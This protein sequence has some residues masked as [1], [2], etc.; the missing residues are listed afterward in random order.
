M[1]VPKV[2]VIIPTYNYA[3]FI[4]EAIES[5]IK[6]TY[7]IGNIEIIVVDDGS[8]DNTNDVLKEYIDSGIIQYHYQENHGKA[9]ATYQAVQKCTGKYIF[10][11]DADD[12]FFPDKIQ[13]YVN[14]FE[15]DEK[16]VH[17]ATPN[18]LLYEKDGSV[19]IEKI[20]LN[21][22]ERTFD[23]SALLQRLYNNNIFFGGGSTFAAR[24]KT[25]RS[26]TI[27]AGVDMFIDEFLLLALLPFG[28]SYFINRP[29][30]TWRV[31]G[32]NFS[33]RN[34]SKENMAKNQERLLNSSASVLD[35]LTQNSYDRDIIKIYRLLHATRK[36]SFKESYDHKNGADIFNYAYG[37]FFKIKPRWSIIWKYNV[38]SRMVPSIFIPTMRK[39]KKLLFANS[40][41]SF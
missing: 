29:L 12:H 5:V 6:Q 16:I 41:H 33:N 22:L 40:R 15:L 1:L 3:R 9:S 14:V 39:L 30:S 11:L 2:S 31:H 20:P 18:R 23:G 17:V 4:L 35:Y 10:N 34:L 21:L 25:L 36:I 28:N 13:T 32:G 24:A 38:M 8:K 27:P 7:G 19:E 37:V 26:I